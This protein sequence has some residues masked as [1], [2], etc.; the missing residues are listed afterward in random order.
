M[1]LHEAYT[2]A[3]WLIERLA[4]ACQQIKVAGGIRRGKPEVKDIEIVCEPRYDHTLNLFG[5]ASNQTSQLDRRLRELIDDGAIAFDANLRRNGDRYK[6][7][8]I[9]D[10]ERTPIDLFI[11]SAGNWGNILA[12]RTGD[13]DFSRALVTSRPQGG[14]MPA[15][16]RQKDGMLWHRGQPIECFT[17]AD[18]FY[19][20][21]FFAIPDPTDRTAA[22]AR[23]LAQ[24]WAA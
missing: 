15:D 23:R 9:R 5:E 18:F 14:L 6:R 4:P 8:V 3:H 2:S 11:A 7:L 22:T 12:I 10:A 24:R 21:G 13:A 19:Q 16:M 20:L 1:E 17:E